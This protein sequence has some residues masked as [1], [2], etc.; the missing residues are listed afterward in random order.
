[1]GRMPLRSLAC[2]AALLLCAGCAGSTWGLEAPEVFLIGLEPH[3][4][5]SLEQ[6]FEI[7]LRVLNPND[8]ALHVNGVDFTLEVNGARLAR[9]VGS[10]EIE[11]PRLGDAVLTVIA[12]TTVFDLLR[13]ALRAGEHDALHYELR[14]RIFLAGTVRRLSFT[15]SGVLGAASGAP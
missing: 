8:R 2:A 1:M 6:R 15:R 4:A 14:G 3:A 5:G 10:E 12:S 13:Q 7:R 11:I 9:G